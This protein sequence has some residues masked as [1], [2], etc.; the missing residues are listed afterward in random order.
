MDEEMQALKYERM[1][2]EP[3]ERLI[4]KMAVPSIISML[5]STVYNIVDTFFVGC[6]STQA[7]AAIGI[8]FSYMA[9]IQAISFF[10]GH[11][12]G[13][14][15]S[16]ALGRQD[17]K[18]AEKMAATGFFSA[19]IFGAVLIVPCFLFINPLLWF[20]GATET[21]LPDARDYMVYILIATPF[22]MGS[23][24][25][26]NQM[27]FQGNAKLGMIGIATGAV[28][29]II[30]DP[31]LIF[32]L[33]MGIRGA[34]VATAISQCVG[35]FV[36]LL[37]SSMSGGV[38]IHWRHF[39]LNWKLY[40]EILAGGLPSLCRQGLASVAAICM[41]QAAGIYGDSAIAAFSIVNRIIMI[42]SAVLIGFGQGFQPVCG[43][44]YGAGLYERVKKAFWFCVRIATIVLIGISICMFAYAEQIVGIFRAG[45]VE[46]IQIGARALRYQS[47]IIP[48]LGVI[49][50]VNMFLQ[51]TGKT[52]RASVLAMSRQGIVFIPVL[53]LLKT[54][55]GLTGISLA[56]PVSDLLTFVM[57]IPFG[58]RGLKELQY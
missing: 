51:T 27:R 50:I 35:F 52:V 17:V 37:M 6:I 14:F 40:K 16:R 41:N 11:G 1:T 55:F 9:M 39:R 8:V 44:N 57:A 22:M 45:D 49:I 56:Q 23:F 19:L 38:N 2:K 10:F 18:D 43:F 33:Q 42:A 47:L 48:F 29:N 3:I 21:I 53:L 54:F 28:L 58:L 20:L 36:L 34:A 26:N 31:I 46:L 4:C 24:V 15:I 5:V 30:L 7:S 13:N 12:S 32:G 25:L